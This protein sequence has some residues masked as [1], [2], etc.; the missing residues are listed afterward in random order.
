MRILG[1][2]LGSRTIGIAMS[3]TAETMALMKETYRFAEADYDAAFE[4]VLKYI[5]KYHIQK[6]VLGFPKHMNG[7]IGEKAQLSLDFKAALEAER[8]VEVILEDERLTT[9]SALR[10]LAALDTK[11]K[12]RKALVDQMAASTILQTYL[13]RER[14][15][16]HGE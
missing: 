6:V 10:E 16:I 14:K 5:D 11:A 12:K 13:D 1:L 2:D 8:S 4:H 9:V 15:K 3:D 7:D